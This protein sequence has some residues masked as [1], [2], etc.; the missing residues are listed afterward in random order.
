MDY[1]EFHEEDLYLFENAN[2]FEKWL[3]ELHNECELI[4]I[5]ELKELVVELEMYDFYLVCKQFEQK[6]LN[7]Q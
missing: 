3:L 6:H 2:H 5:E 1:I 4:E 7:I